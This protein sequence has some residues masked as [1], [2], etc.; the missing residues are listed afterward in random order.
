[1][2]FAVSRVLKDREPSRSNE[3]GWALLGLL[4]ALGVMS[5]VLSSAIVPNVQMQ[6]QRDKE[7]EMIYRGEQ[8]AQGIARYYGRGALAPLSLQLLLTTP[9]GK[10]TDLAKLRDGVTLGVREIKFV[11]P[12]AM[13]DP[14]NS[15]EWE[16]IRI[17]DPRLMRF[18]QAWGVAT[19]TI[20]IGGPQD[21]YAQYF[22]IAGPPQKSAF[23]NSDPTAP[24]VAPVQGVPGQPTPPVQVVPGQPTPPI[25]GRPGRPGDP[26][27]RPPGQKADDD[28]DDDDDDDL[29]NDPLASLLGGPG[30]N[31]APIVGV[32][33]RKK[34]RAMNAY[35]GLENYEDWIFI[36]IP[37]NMPSRPNRVSQ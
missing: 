37:K 9:Y 4:L 22:L 36:Y 17:R 21:P 7:A 18:L 11:R 14:M 30:H 19:G 12:S 24:K 29:S 3:Q 8:M 35:F 13:I 15:S 16:P 27:V 10:L 5:I 1:M 34:G 2:I 28:D 23:K 25:Q 32:A 31:S 20:F 6:V 26:Q 33:P